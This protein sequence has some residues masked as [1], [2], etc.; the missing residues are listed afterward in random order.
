MENFE[1]VHEK[2]E[3]FIRKYYLDRILKGSLLFLAIGLL[4]FLFIS[5]V[6]YFFWLSTTGRMILF[7]SFIGIEFFLLF[8][9]MGI[10]LLK[11]LKLSKGLD[12]Y[13]ASEL[14]GRHFPEVNDKLKNLLQLKDEN[15][16]TE[17]ILASIDQRS[18]RLLHIPFSNAIDIKKKRREAGFLVFPVLIFLALFVAGQADSLF[19]SFHRIQD[20]STVYLKP[21]PFQFLV[22]NDKLTTRE[23]EDYKLQVKVMGDILPGEVKIFQKNSQ[24]LMKQIS[25]GNFEYTFVNPQKNI[26]FRIVSGDV[27]SESKNLRVLKVPK[28]LDFEMEMDYPSYTGLKDEK[29]KGS[30]N[31][32]IPEGTRVSWNFK[33]K[34]AGKINFSTGDSIYNLLVRNDRAFLQKQVKRDLDY[35]VSS[36]N[37]EIQ[38]FE[39]L[40]YKLKVIKD[41]YPQIEVESK[42]DSLNADIQYFKGDLT[43]DYGLS[44]LELV[45]YPE[46]SENESQVISLGINKGSFAEFHYSFPGDLTL[47]KGTNYYFFF[48]VYDNDAVNG[49]KASKSEV[50]SFYKKTDEEM[51]S[52]NLQEQKESIQNLK[53]KLQDFEE[54]DKQ[55][56]EFSRLEKEKENLNYNDRKR[57]ED[58]LKRQKQQNRMMEKFSEKLEKDISKLEDEVVTPLEKEL[59]ERLKKNEGRLKENE[60]LLKELQEYSEK[61]QKED[62]GSKL[63]KLSKQNRNNQRNLEQILELT[64]QYYVEEKKQ[65]LARDLEKLSEK[66]E[67]LSE[68]EQN[69]SVEEQQ[70]LNEEFKDFEKQMDELEKENEN[71][72]RTKDLGREEI[73]EEEI[74]KQQENAIENLKKG[75]KNNA[76][77]SQK[78]A[79]KNMKNMSSRMGQMAMQQ[80]M[81]ELQADAATLRQI[82]DNLLTFSFEQEDLLNAFKKIQQRNPDYALKLKIQS[83]LRENFQ[84]IDDSLFSLA[85]KNPMIGEKIT[86]EITDVQFDLHKAVERL[87]KNEIPQGNASQQYVITGANDLANMLSNILNS[88]EQM[89]ANPQAGNGKGDEE[90]QLPDIIQKQKQ[91]NKKMEQEIEEGNQPANEEG[92]K[93][94]KREEMNGELYEIYKQQQL[95][96]MQMEE[97]RKMNGQSGNGEAE[98]LMKKIEDQLLDK[99]FDEKT[100]ERMK[101]LEYQLL[102]YENAEKRQGMDNKRKSETNQKVF[103]NTLQDQI[104]RAKEYFNSDE[105]L[106]RQILPLRQIYKEKVK[107]YFG[108][109]G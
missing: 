27:S 44:K 36:S 109:S 1:R 55:L 11:L 70:K 90:L 61:I 50:F 30:G 97:I 65:K 81:Q 54:S 72:K 68:D 22:I 5:F 92:Q 80:Q 35:A 88:M 87:S 12:P 33:S 39:P 45:Y 99:G 98:D 48:R 102:K 21:A 41:E 75:D 84:H 43:D 7:W 78:N 53:E 29:L 51:A 69:N 9:F 17:L 28:L 10:P 104:N 31:Y 15:A 16:K 3:A 82:L 77:Q 86:S 40:S 56:E 42:R 91:L 106:N 37:Q 103:R 57:F 4:Y 101:Q 58:F 14:I 25:P 76:T 34:N 32:S 64:K 105:I 62:L 108:T 66:Q 23:G 63:E 94:S 20:Y 49:G 100:L 95:L 73:D 74:E 26:P 60:E 47:E 59:K 93:G 19:G 6:E 46:N 67:N 107:E 89:M 83:N 8:Y 71:L 52:E 24:N 79:A 13:K 85:L 2:L 96:R 38:N 18:S